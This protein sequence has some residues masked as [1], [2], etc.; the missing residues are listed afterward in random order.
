MKKLR[1]VFCSNCTHS[2]TFQAID[3]NLVLC[4]FKF[5]NF[6]YCVSSKK[7][8]LL[9]IFLWARELQGRDG[10]FHSLRRVLSRDLQISVSLISPNTCDHQCLECGLIAPCQLMA[11]RVPH[12]KISSLRWNQSSGWMPGSPS[13]NFTTLGISFKLAWS[14]FF[15]FKV[16][17]GN[18]FLRKSIY[19]ISQYYRHKINDQWPSAMALWKQWWWG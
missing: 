17:A 9:K 12:N 5:F 19:N 3:V 16:G 8:G 6:L 1:E 4:D 7:P 10:P 2:V 13:I 14:S 18:V 15:T 11:T